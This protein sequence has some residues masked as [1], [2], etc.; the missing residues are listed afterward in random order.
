MSEPIGTTRLEEDAEYTATTPGRDNHTPGA[1][2]LGKNRPFRSR[3]NPLAHWNWTADKTLSDW[4]NSTHAWPRV[5]KPPSRRS[6]RTRIALFGVGICLVLCALVGTPLSINYH[7]DYAR[8]LALAQQ[9]IQHIE[10]AGSLMKGLA[11]NP[12]NNQAV[13]SARTHFTAATTNFTQLN[14]NLQQL[15]G[16]FTIVPH[17]GS[18]L[19]AAQKVAPVAV[20]M[21]QAGGIVC[22]ALDVAIARLRDP[23]NAQSQGI[24]PADLQVISQDFTQVQQLFNQATA[25]LNQL[26]PDD[27]AQLDP[28]LA[29]AVRLFHT[30][31]PQV[32]DAFQSIQ[33]ALSIAP[34]ILGIGTP[35]TY[36]IEMLD[37]TEMRPG[38]GFIGSYGT[39]TISGGRLSSLHITDI[40]LLDK[41]YQLA[42]NTTPPVP[43]AYAWFPFGYPSWWMRDSNLEAD[44]P[45]SAKY[46]EQLYHMEGGTPDVQGV[47]A[48]TPWL[49]QDML[50][51]TGP[52]DVPEYNETITAANLIDRIH[53]HQLA[54]EEGQDYIPDPSGH[55]SLRKRFT[56]ILFEHFL[57]RVQQLASTSAM[58]KFARLFLDA[59]HTKDIQVY[60]NNDTAEALLAHE[61]LA[62]AIEAPATG[63]SLMLVDA[64][65]IANKA[66]YFIST[67]VQDQV[68]LDPSGNAHHHTTLT[69]SWPIKPGGDDAYGHDRK[70]TYSDYL[71]IYTP[72]GS[73]LGSLQ[74]LSYL[75]TST[76]FGREV[77]GGNLV[78]YYGGT[79]SVTVD[80]TLPKAATRS[81]TNW[82]YQ[83]FI[84]RP[85][86]ITWQLDV[87][88]T[89]PSC[90]KIAGTPSG[91]TVQKPQRASVKQPLTTD[92]TLGI[93]YTC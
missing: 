85:P 83:D 17:Y 62:S 92:L 11:D 59:L 37:S 47:I 88:L 84:E 9:G 56:E 50:K 19:T 81:A 31:L 3:L 87:Q 67:S 86:G 46:G 90:A 57:A 27:L 39:L 77:W 30:A 7:A 74:G 2:P 52:I 82:H 69:Y 53:Y 80:W 40:D 48:I 73:V 16:I 93:T 78:F 28:R 54:A 91:F 32:Q 10:T 45:T 44:F 35:T 61:H 76:A 1:V 49:I 18:L 43:D 29:S 79:Y 41:T 63:D 64:N 14:A 66:N 71:R 72:P 89:L 70:D 8:D 60:F 36:L 55:S 26:S 58:Q 5:R 42:G 33:I 15:P 38:G 24:T 65:I 21:S 75:S 12:F 68:T 51:V 34:M 23:L 22:D 6:G 4:R 20:E 25:Q 13:A